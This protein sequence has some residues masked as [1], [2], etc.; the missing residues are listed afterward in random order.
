MIPSSFEKKA[1][2]EFNKNVFQ[3]MKEGSLSESDYFFKSTR[4]LKSLQFLLFIIHILEPL[5]HLE[6]K[7]LVLRVH[8]I[9]VLDEAKNVDIDIYDTWDKYRDPFLENFK[10]EVGEIIKNGYLIYQTTFK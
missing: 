3:S 6:I 7:E 1:Y 4:Y 9:F 2:T 10:S 5:S 8:K